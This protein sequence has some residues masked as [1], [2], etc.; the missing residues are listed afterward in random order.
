MSY[1]KDNNTNRVYP[2]VTAGSIQGKLIDF[3]FTFPQKVARD[4]G[5]EPLQTLKSEEVWKKITWVH[6]FSKEQ[7]EEL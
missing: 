2:G 7:S 3:E 6:A 5:R 4:M 1:S